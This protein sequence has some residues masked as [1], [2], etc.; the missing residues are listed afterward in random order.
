MI[1]L[2]QPLFILATIIDGRVDVLWTNDEEKGRK[3]ADA[4]NGLSVLLRAEPV[5]TRRAAPPPPL[6]P[7]WEWVACN[8]LNAMT[9]D[10]P[11]EAFAAMAN[12]RNWPGGFD[13]AVVYKNYV[14]GRWGVKAKDG[15]VP[16]EQG[17]PMATVR[18]RFDVI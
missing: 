12:A 4:A 14:T 17:V 5:S 10:T 7:W 13:S 1:D 15:S 6:E 18:P 16:V 9:F 11:R 8:E 2:H 3:A